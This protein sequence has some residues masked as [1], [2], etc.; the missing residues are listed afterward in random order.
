MTEA[1]EAA[2]VPISSTPQRG[3]EIAE[4]LNARMKSNHENNG[5]K[6]GA[7]NAVEQASYGSF[8]PL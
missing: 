4:F 8:G 7:G 1:A 3:R 6:T 2:I 5:K